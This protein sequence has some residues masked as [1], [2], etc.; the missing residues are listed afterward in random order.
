ME[1]ENTIN[2]NIA[3]S[4]EVVWQDSFK[5]HDARMSELGTEGG[6]LDCLVRANVGE[7]FQF[8]V[9][10]PS[11]HW[12]PFQGV[13]TYDDYPVGFGFRF[14]NLNNDT[15]NIIRQTIAGKKN[16]MPEMA[17]S[18]PQPQIAAPLNPPVLVETQT[19]PREI[20]GR[21]LIAEDDLLTLRILSTIVISEHYAVVTAQDGREAFRILR[22]ES[23]FSAAIFDMNMPHLDGLDLINYMK[24]DD[25]LSRIPIGMVTAEQD[26]KIWNDSLAAGALSLIHI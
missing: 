10:L 26:P 24:T 16:P 17:P 7:L 23:N 2:D 1:T 12:I 8:K 3:V 20:S 19:P 22:E 9:R 6:H 25:R 18:A 21:I 5:K 14:V 4:L 15:R 13:V 11:G